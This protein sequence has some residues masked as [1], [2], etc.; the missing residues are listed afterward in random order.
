[1]GSCT[2]KPADMSRV[3]ITKIDYEMKQIPKLINGKAI[4][5]FATQGSEAGIKHIMTNPHTGKQC[6]YSESMGMYG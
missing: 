4:K 5:I 6:T 2:S 1:M 3:H